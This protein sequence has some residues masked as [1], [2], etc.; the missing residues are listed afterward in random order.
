MNKKSIQNVR[1]K[2]ACSFLVIN[3]IDKPLVTLTKE[4]RGKTQAKPELTKKLPQTAQE[5]KAS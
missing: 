2:R 3:T 1:Q 4:K 5:Y